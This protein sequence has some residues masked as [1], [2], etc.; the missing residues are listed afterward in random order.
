[1]IA[2]DRVARRGPTKAE[3]AGICAA[4]NVA[5]GRHHVHAQSRI[6]HQRDV[7]LPSATI[8]LVLIQAAGP[9]VLRQT[10]GVSDNLTESHVVK[11]PMWP[12]GPGAGQ[13]V[14]GQCQHRAHD[15][16]LRIPIAEPAPEQEDERGFHVA[17]E[18]FARRPVVV[19][20]RIAQ[21]ANAGKTPGAAAVSP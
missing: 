16:V 17:L 21:A 15:V 12:A 2:E 6:A 4:G 8:Q 14:A 11:E 18:Q 5:G 13:S 20:I 19:F 1:M 7:S 10:S 9:I 3:A